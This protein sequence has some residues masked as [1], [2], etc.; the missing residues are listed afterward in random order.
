M[1][2]PPVADAPA[3]WSAFWALLASIE[4]E[5]DR[6]VAD[7]DGRPPPTDRDKARAFD[8]AR[9][10]AEMA[11]AW[12]RMKAAGRAAEATA[13]GADPAAAAAGGVPV[14]ILKRTD[15]EAGETLP[16][17]EAATLRGWCRILRRAV[18][19]AGGLCL[20]APDHIAEDD[21]ETEDER[22]ARWA[23]KDP[24]AGVRKVP[25]WTL[26]AWAALVTADAAGAT[27]QEWKAT[28]ARRNR[29]ARR[30]AAQ[31]VPAAAVPEPGGIEKAVGTEGAFEVAW[32]LLREFTAGRPDLSPR[33]RAILAGRKL[34]EG[35]G[36]D[37]YWRKSP[38]SSGAEAYLAEQ[39]RRTWR[40]LYGTSGVWPDLQA[41]GAAAPADPGWEGLA[42][43]EEIAAQGIPEADLPAGGGL[44]PMP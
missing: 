21:M 30:L 16:P 25:A 5:H 13:P 26:R 29:L 2:D 31:G 7:L 39:L 36:A 32:E 15:P 44:E 18:R 34:P 33:G 11:A 41:A 17:E 38:R 42:T 14:P 12:E 37:G 6:G 40:T 4:A 1:S 35:K 27:P 9:T 8:A 43:I 23:G 28:T 3:S 20:L 22:A 10:A 24:P 19:R